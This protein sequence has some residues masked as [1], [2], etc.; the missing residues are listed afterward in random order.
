MITRKQRTRWSVH[1]RP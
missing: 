1:E